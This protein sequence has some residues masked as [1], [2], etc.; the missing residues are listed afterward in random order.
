MTRRTDDTGWL[1]VQDAALVIVRPYTQVHEAVRRLVAGASAE[2]SRFQCRR[3]SGRWEVRARPPF[4]DIE[5]VLAD[6][7]KFSR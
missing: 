2:L 5:A 1:D 4:L 3:R 6:S 7:A